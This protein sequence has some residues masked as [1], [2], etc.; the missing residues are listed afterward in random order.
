MAVQ[1]LIGTN[2]MGLP[3]TDTGERPM[4]WREGILQ[5]F[6]NGDTPLVALTSAMKKKTTDDPQFHFWEREVSNVRLKLAGDETAVATTI[7]LAADPFGFTGAEQVVP[8]DVLLVEESGELMKVT[9]NDPADQDITVIRGYANTT[10]AAIDEDVD[11]PNLLIV[12]SAFAEGADTPQSVRYRPSKFF[13]YTQIFRDSLQATRT[14]MKTRLRTVDEIRDAKVECLLYHSLKLE[15]AFIHGEK[16]EIVAASGQPERTTQG[17]V[18]FL[19]EH[20]GSTNVVNA[21]GSVDM[22]TFE[23]TT[24]EIFRFGSNEKMAFVG[25]RAML[26]FQQMARKNSSFEITPAQK[27]YGMDIRRFYCPGGTLVLKTHPLF[28]QV[29]SDLVRASAYYGMDSWALI[30]DMGEL[31]YRP[32]RGS[33]TQYLPDRQDNG[34]DGLKSE[35]LTECGLEIHHAKQ[36][37]LWKELTAGVADTAP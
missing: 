28:N 14:A 3:G 1:G 29:Q 12:G 4:N 19:E 11:N 16:D 35:Y 33:D 15:Y 36:H 32:L 9:A 10:A 18:K 13:N 27:E 17:I 21:G 26:A 25:N 20:V 6:P 7:T 22:D 31:V 30:L 8:G 2:Q 37:F 34:T 24:L 23:A 5:R